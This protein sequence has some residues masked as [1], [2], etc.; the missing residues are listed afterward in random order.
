MDNLSLIIV[1][2]IG[3]VLFG[4]VAFAVVLYLFWKEKKGRR[5]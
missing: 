4:I 5:E 2:F 1:L 3:G